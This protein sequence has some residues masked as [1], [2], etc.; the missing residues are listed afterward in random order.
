MYK[1]CVS[2][3]LNIYIEDYKHRSNINFTVMF[4]NSHMLH[5]Y[6]TGNVLQNRPPNFY[7]SFVSSSQNLCYFLSEDSRGSFMVSLSYPCVQPS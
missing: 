2:M 7:F 4:E 6:N 5:V 1:F 3:F